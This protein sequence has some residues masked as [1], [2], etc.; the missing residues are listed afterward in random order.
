MG[1]QHCTKIYNSTNETLKVSI[2][3][4]NDLVSSYE[5]TAGDHICQP[6]SHGD[7]RVELFT[8]NKEGIFL[9]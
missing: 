1:N 4:P 5:I 6:T 9:Y 3:H 8:K 2:Q 7:V